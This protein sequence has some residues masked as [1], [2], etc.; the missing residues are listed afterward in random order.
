M[1]LRGELPMIISIFRSPGGHWFIV[2]TDGPQ[3]VWE[4][5]PAAESELQERLGGRHRAKFEADWD[6][7]ELVIGQELDLPPEVVDGPKG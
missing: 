5:P 2:P 7:E 6:G 4:V 3:A 1:T